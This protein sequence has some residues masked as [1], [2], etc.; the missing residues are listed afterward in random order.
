[1]PPMSVVDGRL[2]GQLRRRPEVEVGGRERI[3]RVAEGVQLART[4]PVGRTWSRKNGPVADDQVAV[5]RR[6]SPGPPGSGRPPRPG[7]T[8]VR[9]PIWNTPAG[10]RLLALR[11][12]AA[13]GPRALASLRHDQAQ[14]GHVVARRGGVAV[15]RA[16]LVEHQ[17]VHRREDLPGHAR[18]TS[19]WRTPRSGPRRSASSRRTPRAGRRRSGG[20]P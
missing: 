20:S 2:D 19:G 4:A 13:S 12:G 5:R 8:S 16:A 15:G 7:V 1:M 17:V 14:P 3:G 11:T 9:P 10:H 6:T 18:A